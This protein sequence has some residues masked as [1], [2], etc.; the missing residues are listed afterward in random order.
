MNTNKTF[1]SALL[2]G[3]LFGSLAAAPVF[4]QTTTQIPTTEI[5][6]PDTSNSANWSGYITQNAQ[7]YTAVGATWVVP[8]PQSSVEA[9]ADATWVGIGGVSSRDLI[10][11]GTQALVE[12][13][14]VEYRAWYELLP[15]SQ[16]IIP[17]KVRGGDK[18]VVSVSERTTNKWNISFTNLTTGKTYEINVPYISSHSSAEWI[19]EM[20]ATRIAGELSFIPLDNFGSVSF[21]GG[22]TFADGNQYTI[23]SSGAQSITMGRGALSLA[24]PSLLSTDGGGFSVARMNVDATSPT[25]SIYSYTRSTRRAGTVRQIIVTLLPNGQF[26]IYT[27]GS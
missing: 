26:R 16:R 17:L 9:A 10:Q 15:G 18:V 8:M 25:Q 3:I 6:N 19:E 14:Q 2:I 13:G 11:A 1:V 12:D 27:F 21:S 4:A 23:L 7:S 22:Y 5:P 24:T 20:P